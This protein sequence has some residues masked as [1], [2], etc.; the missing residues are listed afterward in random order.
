MP[1]QWVGCRKRLYGRA[2]NVTNEVR[3]NIWHPGAFGQFGFVNCR[4]EGF[5]LDP[6]IDAVQL[7]PWGLQPA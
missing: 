2:S 5:D 7:T 6:A 4:S 1:S 3:K